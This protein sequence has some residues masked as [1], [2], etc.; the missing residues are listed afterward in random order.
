MGG[1]FGEALT[2]VRGAVQVRAVRRGV[3]RVMIGG[4]RDSRGSMALLT[5]EQIEEA[6][7]SLDAELGRAG[8]RASIHIV[9]GAAM[10]L[11]F[12]ARESTRDIDAWFAP[13]SAVRAAA[14]RVA[15]TLDLPA[16]WLNDAAKAFVPPGAGFE[17]WRSLAHLDIFVADAETLLAMKCAAARTQED[18]AD[19]RLLADRLGLTSSAAALAVVTKYY[20]E[21]RLPVRTRLLLEELLDDGS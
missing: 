20:P 12:R 21:D 10:C 8:Q 1:G 17:A 4:E 3:F 5:R 15:A 9:G 16:D 11:V 18:S 7:A 13:A 2:P 19:I 6:L 14:A